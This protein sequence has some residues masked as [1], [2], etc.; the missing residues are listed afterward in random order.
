MERGESSVDDPP[1]KELLGFVHEF[2][3]L[4]KSLP[5]ESRLALFKACV[6]SLLVGIRLCVVGVRVN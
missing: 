4:A 3:T 6:G 1:Q 5:Q 2:L